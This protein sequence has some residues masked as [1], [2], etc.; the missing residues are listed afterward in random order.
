[1]YSAAL[2]SALSDNDRD[3]DLI[4]FNVNSLNTLLTDRYTIPL[5]DSLYNERTKITQTRTCQFC[6]EK[7]HRTITDEEGN[8][9]KE[10]YEEKTQ[11]PINQIKIYDE[12]LPYFERIIT[13]L[14]SIKSWKCPKCSNINKV[15]DTPISDKRYGSNATFGVCYEQPKYS[16]FNRSSFDKISMKWVTDFLREIDMGLMAF[17]KEYFDQ[18]GEEMSQEIKHIGEK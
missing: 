16:I 2:I 10:F 7:K 8:Q 18:H 9:S 13:G 4:S 14:S 6:V 15:K 3:W 17:Q 12:P 5:S 1:M 11:I